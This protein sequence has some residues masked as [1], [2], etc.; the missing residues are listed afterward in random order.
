MGCTSAKQVSAVPSDEEGRGK[1]YSNGDLYSDEYKLKGVEEV[2]YM[3]GEENR[4]NA[5][6]Q[7]NLEKSNAQH[8]GKNQKEVTSSNK[9]NIHTS[10][11]QQEFFRMLDEKIEKGRD[12]CSEEEE[13]GT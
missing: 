4:V 5:R 3:R 6:N 7:E 8:R 12:Y 1:N 2:K 11:S 9:A 13:D 10:E